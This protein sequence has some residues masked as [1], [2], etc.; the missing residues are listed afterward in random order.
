MRWNDRTT[1]VLAAVKT[2]VKDKK[3]FF[4]KDKPL[5]ALSP[6]QVILQIKDKPEMLFEAF[7]DLYMDKP[8]VYL[9]NIKADFEEKIKN[10]KTNLKLGFDIN[11]KAEKKELKNT[12]DFLN[13]RCSG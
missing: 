1:F 10:F 3:W 5:V 4:V 11:S 8:S 9:K 13:S 12:E 2:A 6:R 7:D